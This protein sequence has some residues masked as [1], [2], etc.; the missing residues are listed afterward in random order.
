MKITIK[1]VNMTVKMPINLNKI[2]LF[3]VILSL[4]GC[5]GSSSSSDEKDTTAPVITVAGSSPLT[6]ALDSTYVDQGATAQDDVDSSVTVTTTGTVDTTTVGSYT[7]TYTAE[8]AAG[9]TATATRVVDVITPSQGVLLDSPVAGIGYRT[10]SSEGLTDEIGQFPFLPGEAVIFFIGDLTFP[11]VVAT[12]VVTPENIA[13]GD[14]TTQTNI[15]QI[16]QTLDEDGNPDNGISIIDG[17]DTAFTGTT[18][19]IT[20]TEFDANVVNELAV[21]DGALSLVSETEADAHFGSTL[22]SQLL[23]SWVFSEGENMRNILTFIDDSHYAIFHEHSDANDDC[24]DI[25]GC[26]M[27]GSGEYGSYTWDIETKAFTSTVI[28]ESDGSGGLGGLSAIVN[29]EGNMLEI[30][31]DD[32]PDAVLFSKISDSSNS[33]IGSWIVGSGNISNINILTFLSTNEYVIFHNANGESDTGEVA[34]AVSGEF[35]RYSLEGITFTI[36]STTVDSDGEGG[37]YNEDDPATALETLEL[38]PWGDLVFTDSIDGPA[39]I[40]RIGTYAVDLQDYDANGSLGTITTQRELFGFSTS[41]INKTWQ[42][43]F[44]LLSDADITLEF[45]L[46]TGGEGT[47]KEISE[48]DTTVINWQWNSTGDIV[49]TFNDGESDFV[50]TLVNLAAQS[51]TGMPILVSFRS[52]DTPPENTLIETKLVEVN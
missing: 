5:G 30:L 36:L 35:G 23:G 45:T 34:Q 32:E 44:D 29:I 24:N 12:G 16:L 19:D 18:L 37:L 49:I 1:E 7:I 41:I 52:N 15:L 39:N 2:F 38:E 17:A 50:V 26:Q 25:E 6:I 8:D 10:D 31:I 51:S 40:A 48:V 33:L 4:T 13:A 43:A 3:S 14:N 11:A 21:I 9:N 42:M 20:N 22:K 27:A 46:L 47:M 28:S